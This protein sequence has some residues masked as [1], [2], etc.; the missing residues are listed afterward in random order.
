MN[1][2]V[3]NLWPWGI[4]VAMASPPLMDGEAQLGKRTREAALMQQ[5]LGPPCLG[6]ESV[7][8][9]ECLL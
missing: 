6:P 2:L 3:P 4:L 9:P 8:P 7:P 5:A 1:W